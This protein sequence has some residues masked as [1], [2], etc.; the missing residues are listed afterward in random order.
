LKQRQ[1]VGGLRALE[2][3]FG[4][5]HEFVETEQRQVLI[6][7]LRHQQDLGRFSR[8][9]GGEILLQCCFAQA[10]QAAKEIDLPRRGQVN[11]IRPLY[12]RLFDG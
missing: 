4:H 6:R 3:T 5:R 2:R 1:L 11:G 12:E 10:S 8:L 7:D 9:G